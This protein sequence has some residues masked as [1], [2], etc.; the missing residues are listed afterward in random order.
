[1]LSVQAP[2]FSVSPW[3]AV[4]LAVFC[5]VRRLQHSAAAISATTLQMS[6]TG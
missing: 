2:L 6:S 1:M 3:C 5:Q 4:A